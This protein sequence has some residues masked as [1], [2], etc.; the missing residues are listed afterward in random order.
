M[1]RSAGAMR[2]LRLHHFAARI[3]RQGVARRDVSSR[4]VQWLYYS[5]SE[6]GRIMPHTLTI[7]DANVTTWSRRAPYHFSGNRSR[8]MGNFVR[9][10]VC[11]FRR[12]TDTPPRVTV[13]PASFNTTRYTRPLAYC[14]TTQYLQT[15]SHPNTTRPP[16]KRKPLNVTQDGRY[17]PG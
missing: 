13:A 11:R 15:I 9:P 3:C 5:Y 10:R 1:R 7:I 4:G 8:G 17:A 6:A 2:P 16:S 14:W 12:V